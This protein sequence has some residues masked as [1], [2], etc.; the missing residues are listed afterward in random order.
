MHIHRLLLPLLGAAL[1]ALP[2]LAQPSQP[3]APP[4]RTDAGDWVSQLPPDQWQT[5]NL[6]GLDV[7]SSNNG[8]KIG[9][10]DGLIFGDSGRVQMVVIAVGGYL[11]LRERAI[12]VPFNQ[13]K[14]VN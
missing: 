8:D 12:A 11:A 7:Y 4:T 13:I 10:I 6:E 9:D 3:T 1:I 14:F 2:A 5:S